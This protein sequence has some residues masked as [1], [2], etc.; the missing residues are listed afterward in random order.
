[1]IKQIFALVLVNL[2]KAIKAHLHRELLLIDDKLTAR[3]DMLQIQLEREVD[4]A[5]KAKTELERILN[6]VNREVD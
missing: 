6:L 2:L 5:M 3:K 4:D 1:M